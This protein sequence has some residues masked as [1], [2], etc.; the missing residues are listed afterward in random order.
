MTVEPEAATIDRPP[1]RPPPAGLILSY[2]RIAP[3]QI[4]PWGMRVSPEVFESQMAALREIGEPVTLAELAG[5]GPAKRPQIAV[6]FD[7]GYADNLDL[8][9]PVLRRNA[10]PATLFVATGYIGKLHYWWEALE[11]VFLRPGHLPARLEFGRG[12]R[13]FAWDLGAAADYTAAQHAADVASFTWRGLSGTRIRLYFEV[14]EALWSIPHPARLSL[15]EDILNWS[16]TMPSRLAAARPMTEEE[17]RQFA[18]SPLIAIGGHGVNHL[19]LDGLSDAEQDTEIAG[20]KSRLEDLIGRTVDSFAYPHG[21]YGEDTLR[22][23]ARHGFT[24]ACTTRQTSVC[25]LDLPLLLPRA[26][27]KNWTGAEFAGRLKKW[28]AKR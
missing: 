8:G 15:V 12:E 2:H 27:I 1:P 5:S 13:L 11:E 23:L 20:C 28:L 10:V 6:T 21:K 26:V 3:N 18:A 4:D 25:A 24:L 14:Y 7:D 19:A 17:L 9:L 22:N 16:T